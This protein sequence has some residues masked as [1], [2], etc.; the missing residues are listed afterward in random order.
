MLLL[1]DGGLLIF[2]GERSRSIDCVDIVLEM[3]LLRRREGY[4]SSS[5]TLVA[6]ISMSETSGALFAAA[7]E[8]CTFVSDVQRRQGTG[9]T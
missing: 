3:F 9:C 4:C 8:Y 2:R 6:R 1:D 7:R 5:Y